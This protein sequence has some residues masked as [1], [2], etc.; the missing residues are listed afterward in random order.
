MHCSKLHNLF[1]LKTRFSGN[2]SV[3]A[4]SDIRL[5]GKIKK[6]FPTETFPL[7]SVLFLKSFSIC[8]FLLKLMFCFHSSVFTRSLLFYDLLWSGM[9]RKK[10]KEKLHEPLIKFSFLLHKKCDSD[11][12]KRGFLVQNFEVYLWL[13]FWVK[14]SFKFPSG[15]MSRE[16]KVWQE[17]W[18]YGSCQTN[19]K[20]SV[21]IAVAWCFSHWG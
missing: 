14:R 19:A 12:S 9:A 16:G 1:K 2:E 6:L 21:A 15:R 13:K 18:L 4:T 11:A 8:F 7:R 10:R 3:H 5:F 20:L 17:N